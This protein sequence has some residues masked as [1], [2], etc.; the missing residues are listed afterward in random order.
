LDKEGK[1]TEKGVSFKIGPEGGSLDAR[2]AKQRHI[3][4]V[5]GNLQEGGLKKLGGATALSAKHKRGAPRRLRASRKDSLTTQ[6]ILLAS[7]IGRKR[8]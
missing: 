2:N 5:L 1:Y 8:V 6:Q 4:K 3:G 7:D